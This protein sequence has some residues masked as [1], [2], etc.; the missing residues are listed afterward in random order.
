MTVARDRVRLYDVALLDYEPLRIEMFVEPESAYLGPLRKFR[1]VAVDKE[2]FTVAFIE[3][4][5]A[6]GVFYDIGANVGSYTLLAAARGLQV[7]AF[8]PML[9]NLD[10]LVA[11]LEL[12]GWGDR[13][14][15]VPHGLAAETG[16]AW[17]HYGDTRP[18]S[19]TF[20]WGDPKPAQMPGHGF[21]RTLASVAPLDELIGRYHLPLPTHIK[22]DVDGNEAATLA[23]MT[24]VLALPKLAGIIIELH[25]EGEAE[26]IH[27][28]DA[29]GWAVAER[30]DV[31]QIAYARF[32]RMQTTAPVVKQ[33]RKKLAA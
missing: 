3:S 11:N 10:M 5:P 20:V 12:N 32:E 28:L 26:I 29:A 21:H 9:R 22:I 17:V 16:M 24:Q 30:W 33:R 15:P 25:P 2:P 7:V 19:A 6:G 14:W 18:G 8:E 4:I 23:G 1:A 31:R 27:L 13:V